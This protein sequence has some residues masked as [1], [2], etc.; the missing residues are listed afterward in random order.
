MGIVD[1]HAHLFTRSFFHALAEASPL[2]GTVEEKLA[3][4]QAKTG[5]ELPGDVDDHA[6][7]W[8]S[9][10]DTNEVEHLVGFASHPAEVPDVTAILKQ[11]EGRMT[12]MAMVDP[13]AE[14]AA[15]KV[16]K[17]LEGG[18]FKGVLTFPAMHHFEVSG[19][20]MTSVLEVLRAKRGVCY[21]HCGQLVV[22]LRDLLGLPRGYDLR[23]ANPLAII[24]AADAFPEVTFVIPHFGAG[25]FR[26]TLIAGAQ[27]PNIVVDTSSSN[28][29]IKT[30]PGLDLREVLARAL[31]VF[32]PERVLLGTDS[33]VFPA[34]WR[35]D[36]VAEQQNLVL[37]LGA[38]DE[39][40]ELFIGGNAKRVLGIG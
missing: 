4:V 3:A 9:E 14:G 27:C 11:A 6:R 19:E 13:T 10:L 22:K 1:F 39:E 32:G 24:P 15:G 8:N 17:L 31:D 36:R 38:S 29:W 18:L 33:G 21:V 20:A 2:P 12:G 7:R 40:Q 5:I 25:F 37:E 26:E 23:F 35:G 30:H 28:G 34:G 16:E